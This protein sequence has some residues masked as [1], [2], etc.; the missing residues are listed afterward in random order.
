MPLTLFA[1]VEWISH[2]HHLLLQDT[3]K[4]S[5]DAVISGI[6][7]HPTNNCLAVTDVEGKIGNWEDAVPSHFP[8]PGQPMTDA[9]MQREKDAL[10]DLYR[11]DGD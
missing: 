6:S 8:P 7:W 11:L 3:G 10:A 1:P 4:V 9:D 2:S 5:H